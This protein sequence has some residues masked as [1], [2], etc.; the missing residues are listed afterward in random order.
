M[1]L[2]IGNAGTVPYYSEWNVIDLNGLNTKEVIFEP[3]SLETMLFEEDVTDLIV[4]NVGSKPR[5]ISNE[6]AYSQILYDKAIEMGMERIGIFSLQ[7]TYNL[8]VLGYPNT[9]LAEYLEENVDF[10]DK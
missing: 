5:I 6:Y 2:A 7:R 10:R 1:T 4:I 8:W 9:E 3:D